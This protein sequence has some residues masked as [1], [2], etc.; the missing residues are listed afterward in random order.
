MDYVFS[1]GL[2]AGLSITFC[3]K[4]NRSLLKIIEYYT[5]YCPK[6]K[7]KSKQDAKIPEVWQNKDVLLRK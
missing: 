7:K 6:S 1:S 3:T 4:I 5:C 2:I